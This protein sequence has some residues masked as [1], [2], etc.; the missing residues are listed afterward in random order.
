M[1]DL[2]ADL[3]GQLFVIYSKPADEHSDLLFHDAINTVV[4][5]V[6]FHSFPDPDEAE[7]TSEMKVVAIRNFLQ[8]P[9]IKVLP[10]PGYDIST[11][12]RFECV[13]HN[14]NSSK[15]FGLFRCYGRPEKFVELDA[16]LALE[17]KQI[18]GGTCEKV[19][20][21]GNIGSG[22]SHLIAMH[23]VYQHCIRRI[24]PKL[25]L[26][27]PIYID[28]CSICLQK[29][30]K[31]R[32]LGARLRSAVLLA[33]GCAR[34]GDG[35][36]ALLQ[37]LVD[38]H[39]LT[40]ARGNDSDCESFLVGLEEVFR[41]ALDLSPP[42]GFNIVLYVDD[43]NS[44]DRAESD[45]TC[46]NTQSF[47]L[48]TLS[49]L[50]SLQRGVVAISAGCGRKAEV[51]EA[52]STNQSTQNPE[53]L[54]YDGLTADEWVV[55]KEHETVGSVYKRLTTS[56]Q[57]Q[58]DDLTGLVPL[59]ISRMCAL[60]RENDAAG[61]WD[62]KAGVPREQ[63]QGLSEVHQTSPDTPV[64]WT[65]V[66]AAYYADKSERGVSGG[67]IL[68]HLK[69]FVGQT[70]ARKEIAH[71]STKSIVLTEMVKLFKGDAGSVTCDL[72]D[73]RYFRQVDN[74]TVRPIC[75]FVR[76]IY[77]GVLRKEQVDN[78]AFTLLQEF[79]WYSRVA[80]RG[81]PSERGFA[82]E[83]F[84]I[85]CLSDAAFVTKVVN[86]APEGVIALIASSA[87]KVVHFEQNFPAREELSTSGC[88]AYV[89]DKWNLR[90]VDLV[91]RIVLEKLTFICAMQITLQSP[92]EHR[93]SL[94]FYTR[95]YKI[96][97]K[98]PDEV[99]QCDYSRYETASEAAN[100]SATHQLVWVLLHD[101][102]AVD[103][104]V[105]LPV[106]PVPPATRSNASQRFK[107]NLN[108]AQ[109]VVD[110]EIGEQGSREVHHKRFKLE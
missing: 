100:G 84:F 37:E 108:F 70:L 66:I 13:L 65:G 93:S 55:V 92:Q 106:P 76:V 53:F 87:I 16:T 33:A 39:V 61:E 15:G 29:T 18:H 101:P 81:N 8:S 96:N 12:K 85:A 99:P 38:K 109:Q 28:H 2:A 60:V 64:D 62:V 54:V 72:Y 78:A 40:K 90:H 105:T 82:L 80:N 42:S 95:P 63:S 32:L 23:V 86:G 52:S 11:N 104:E 94:D 74:M 77:E 59:F 46:N 91:L 57:V 10:F 31:K 107:R 102:N 35:V 43:W 69:K 83:S 21:F 98:D 20:I 88:T 17:L 30:A 51:R 26:W 25:S 75:G 71:L 48:E 34:A 44:V 27:L 49:D 4:K 9:V 56:Q 79:K 6:L 47:W 110:L 45:V 67:W 68:D 19:E 36:A 97:Q 1:I 24:D 103:V 50:M 58:F 73:H 14:D 89:P 7:I 5:I 22:K 3:E 41:A